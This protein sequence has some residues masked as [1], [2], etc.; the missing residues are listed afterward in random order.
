MDEVAGRLARGD[1]PVTGRLG[2]GL[3]CTAALAAVAGRDPN[4]EDG[5]TE[6]AGLA[7]RDPP[8]DAGR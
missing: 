3:S 7:P 8:A 1:K 6:A 5:R 2:L 4:A